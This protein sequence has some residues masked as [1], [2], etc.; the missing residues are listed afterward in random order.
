MPVA[1]FLN[2]IHKL[3]LIYYNINQNI[4]IIKRKQEQALFYFYDKKK[5]CLLQGVV[6]QGVTMIH[7]NPYVLYTKMTL[8]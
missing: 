7:I 8:S 1:T 2:G 6:V 5:H 4:F 3:F